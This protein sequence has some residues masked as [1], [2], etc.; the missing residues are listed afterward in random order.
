MDSQD[1]FNRRRKNSRVTVSQMQ[2]YPSC[3]SKAN[4]RV[5]TVTEDSN[6]NNSQK[7]HKQ[8]NPNGENVDKHVDQHISKIQC[9]S[10]C[11]VD[12]P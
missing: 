9:N 11:N 6:R 3:Y 10:T 5:A 1:H 8:A 7:N 12:N 4:Q 2:Q